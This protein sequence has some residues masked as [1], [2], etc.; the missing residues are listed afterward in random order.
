MILPYNITGFGVDR[1][2]YADDLALGF[3][4]KDEGELKDNIDKAMNDVEDWCKVNLLCLNSDKTKDIKFSLFADSSSQDNVSSMNFLGITLDSSLNWEDHVD[5]VAFKVNKG[6]FAIRRLRDGVNLDVLKQVYFAMIHSHLSY[7]T[8]LWAHS[9]E[10]QRVFV[11]QK[12]A[13]RLICRLKL[14]DHCKASFKKLKI[15]TLP[16]IFIYQCLLYIKE[17]ISILL[18]QTQRHNYNTRGKN[19]VVTTCCNYTKTQQSFYY[20]AIKMFNA[21]PLTF[22]QLPLKIFKT[23]FK[24]K[25]IEKSIYSTEEYFELSHEFF[26][27]I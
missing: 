11:L 16:S 4:S 12:R 3:K 2:L 9:N 5:K 10:S 15:M 27:L 6:I 20:L 19:N 24:K 7:G 26:S 22:R 1:Y 8:I 14:R 17:N 13:V 18:T 21:L 25:L 23:E